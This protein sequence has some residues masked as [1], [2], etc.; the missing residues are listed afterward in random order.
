MKT[1]IKQGMVCM[2]LAKIM[3]TWSLDLTAF[4]CCFITYL[5]WNSQVAYSPFSHYVLVRGNCVGKKRTFSPIAQEQCEVEFCSYFGSLQK[6]CSDALRAANIMLGCE[7]LSFQNHLWRIRTKS[8]NNV[9]S[10]SAESFLLKS[11]R[12]RL[13]WHRSANFCFIS[14][15]CT[16]LSFYGASACKFAM[17]NVCSFR[18][19]A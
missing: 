6:L 11:S 2:L 5:L 13:N 17:N 16:G 1:S 19:S 9:W 7:T 10:W 15:L 12:W 18:W 14:S 4:L 3:L 8:V